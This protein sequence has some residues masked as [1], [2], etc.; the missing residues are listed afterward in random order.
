MERLA[1]F[2]ELVLRCRAE[3]AKSYIS[4]ALACYRAGA[5]RACIITTWIAVVFDIIE[6]I[7]DLSFSG[8]KGAKSLLDTFERYQRQV[9]EGNKEAVK[10]LLIFEREIL[11]KS[12]DTLQLLDNHQFIELSRLREDR[13]RCAHPSFQQSGLPYHPSSELARVHLRNAI[14]HLLAQSPVQGKEALGALEKIISSE[15]FPIELEDARIVLEESHLDRPSESLVKGLAD[16][17]IFKFFE[18]DINHSGRKRIVVALKI[19]LEKDRVLTENRLKVHFNKI[20]DR[21]LDEDIPKCVL[22]AGLISECM[23]VLEPAKLSKFNYF[24]QNGPGIEVAKV[25]KYCLGDPR[26]RSKAVER[27][28]T[29]KDV[30][31]ALAIKSK[32]EDSV[33]IGRAVELYTQVHSWQHANSLTKNL[34]LPIIR[35][36]DESQIEEI[37]RAASSREA[38][39]IGSGGFSDFLDALLNEKV[40][41]HEKFIELAEKTDLEKYIYPECLD[42]E[43]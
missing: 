34:I 43:D 38:D 33:V 25:I 28:S 8:N 27:L 12:R 3:T 7:R 5:Y 24:I 9:D 11:E 1:D 26:L 35:F 32:C 22:F 42:S 4:E 2:D 30:E 16:K 17:L 6:K 13:H 20:I 23:I 14:V 31:L 21:V 29:F 39:L 40:L 15:Y 19:L 37:F 36:L 41:S 10:Q 18:A